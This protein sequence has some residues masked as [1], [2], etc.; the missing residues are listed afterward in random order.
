M[1]EQSFVYIYIYREKDSVCVCVCCHCVA[2]TRTS[3]KTGA[4][5]SAVASS[6]II[7]KIHHHI[8][9]VC[10]HV[11]DSSLQTPR[12][13]VCETYR[14]IYICISI[15]AD[16]KRIFIYISGFVCLFVSNDRLSEYSI[17]YLN[18]MIYI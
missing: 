4:G 2:I 11:W 6:T 10:V 5:G 12:V 17:V 16:C 15:D 14:Y 13:S 8:D 1:Y 3:R 9:S 18:Y 7:V